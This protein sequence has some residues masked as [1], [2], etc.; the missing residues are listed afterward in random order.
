MANVARVGVDL[1]GPDLIVADP[2]LTVLVENLPTAK[3][4]SITNTGDI[5]VTSLSPTVFANG[6]PLANI[7][8][9]TA[10]GKTVI[11][12]AATVFSDAIPGIDPST[13]A[14]VSQDEIYFSQGPEAARVYRQSLVKSGLMT[15]AQ[16]DAGDKAS[17]EFSKKPAEKTPTYNGPTVAAD[18]KAV[19]G[20]TVFPDSTKLTT[21]GTTLSDLLRKVLYPQHNIIAQ[22]GLSKDQIVCNLANLAQNIWEPLKAK[23]PDV[24]ITNS[25]REGNGQEQ[26]GT[27]QAMDIQF[28]GLSSNKYLERAQWIKANLPFDQLLLECTTGG[29][30]GGSIWIHI[31]HYSGT[32]IHV[33]AKPEG[34]W[35]AT[36]ID[37]ANFNS[38]L[39]D[40]SGIPGI[41]P[42]PA[43]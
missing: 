8:S 39:R 2:G 1:A 33:H 10:R 40:L 22:K 17:A 12:G 38:G 6:R 41:R 32:G 30:N 16:V 27:G 36:M 24:F 42:I 28:H 37:N 43:A 29:K 23:Y 5:I 21:K 18:C 25:F 20:M 35:Y 34:N 15:Q 11:S 19:H 7:G 9:V 4:G 31:S 13:L 26:H 3:I 14:V